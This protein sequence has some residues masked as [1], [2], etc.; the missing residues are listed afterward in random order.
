MVLL[1]TSSMA[2]CSHIPVPVCLLGKLDTVTLQLRVLPA[3]PYSPPDS[4]LTVA[5]LQQSPSITL[6]FFCLSLQAASDTTLLYIRVFSFLLPLPEIYKHSQYLIPSTSV[7]QSALFLLCLP[8]SIVYKQKVAPIPLL[9]Q[10]PL[11]QQVL[12]DLPV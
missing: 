5:H 6:S 10:H 7:Y 1:S 8:L 9:T 11:P 3:S 2:F 4:L 12:H